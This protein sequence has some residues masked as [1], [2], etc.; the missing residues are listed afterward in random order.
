MGA[1]PDD[2]ERTPSQLVRLPDGSYLVGGRQW[3]EELN[4]S[5]DWDLPKKKDYET[6]AG[7]VADLLGR[8]PVPGDMAELPGWRLKV[9]QVEHHHAERV[10]IV[11]TASGK[12]AQR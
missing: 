12:T 3:I 10:R 9:R 8:I 1:I 4:E 11:R 5:L 2:R 7:L 6:V